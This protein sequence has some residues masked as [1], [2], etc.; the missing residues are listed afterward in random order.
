M[1]RIYL[2][3]DRDQWWVLADML[4]NLLVPQNAGKLGRRTTVR[5]SRMTRLHLVS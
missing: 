1:D 4:M 3:Q 5:F 2:V